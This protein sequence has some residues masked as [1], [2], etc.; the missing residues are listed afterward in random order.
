MTSS[1]FISAESAGAAYVPWRAPEVDDSLSARPADPATIRERARQ[2]GYDAG[3]A[4]GADEASQRV[5]YLDSVLSVLARPIEDLDETVSQELVALVT[6]LAGQLVRR[7]LEL[8][9]THLIG[10]VREGIAA[11]PAAARNVTILL[12]PQDAELIR[13]Q[14]TFQQGDRP[15]AIETDPLLS[16]GDCRLTTDTSEVDGRLDTRL[17][18]VVGAMIHAGRRSND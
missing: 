4:A 12:N 8:D 16:R 9:P 10:V 1:K 7:E 14:L 2:Q 15:W 13:D 11:L 6:A 18:R 17:A 5:S 3:L